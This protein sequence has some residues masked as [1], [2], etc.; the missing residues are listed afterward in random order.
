MRIDELRKF[1]LEQQVPFSEEELQNGY[2]LR[3]ETGEI[4][5]AYNTGK[6]VC[7]G[8]ATELS[9]AVKN[10]K[11]T[12]G[13]TSKVQ[14]LAPEAVPSEV[15]P[16]KAADKPVFIVYGHDK[17]AREGLELLLHKMDLEPIVL[18]DHFK[19]GQW[20]SLQNR[21]T[22]RTRDT[23]LLPCQRQLRQV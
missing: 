20:L 5:A 2:L 18:S 9:K 12:V 21:P 8:K 1:L 19:S 11:Q 10:W 14:L 23:T 3:C 15:V 4:F 7:Q 6:V 22:G 16:P 17:A 13:K